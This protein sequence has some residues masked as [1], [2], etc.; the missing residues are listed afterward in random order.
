M[1][2]TL[3][4]PLLVLLALAALARAGEVPSMSSL[5]WGELGVVVAED[6]EFGFPD[7]DS[8]AR[9]VL[10]GGGYINY[11]ALRRDNVPRSVRDGGGGSSSAGS[12]GRSERNESGTTRDEVGLTC[13]VE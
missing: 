13:R 6:D 11:G 7:G 2:H 3:L 8:V 5:E 12:R 4:L 9:Q 10:Q 1:A